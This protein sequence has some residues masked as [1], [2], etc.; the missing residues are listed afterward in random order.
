M[1]HRIGWI[2]RK[3]L[4]LYILSCQDSEDGGFS[5]RPGNVADVFHCYF[6]MAGLSLLG[7]G[8]FSSIDPV[9]ALPVSV[10]AKLKLPV[11]Y[12]TK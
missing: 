2:D 7:Y 12:G 3:K 10:C 5:D 9:F 8:Q 4:A 1:L 11:R 6:G